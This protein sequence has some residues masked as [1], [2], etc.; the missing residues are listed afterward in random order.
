VNLLENPTALALERL[1]RRGL[2]ARLHATE[3]STHR[4]SDAARTA[5]TAL[6]AI[7]KTVVFRGA[8]GPV[9]A[10]VAGSERVHRRHL[11]H[12]I[13]QRVEPA[14]A[15]YL[16]E[17]LGV[18]AGGATPLV[19]PPTAIVV[20]DEQL[21]ARSHVWLSAGTPKAIVEVPGELLAELPGVLLARVGRAA[22][23]ATQPALRDHER[24]ATPPADAAHERTTPA[25][26]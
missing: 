5:G 18:V 1:A 2:R 25:G 23:E 7:A 14:P 20:V 8:R 21:V 11:E 13:G 3:A 22:E 4:A 12:V 10:V 16:P 19:A 17:A 15:P 9:L 24:R 26:R 6:E